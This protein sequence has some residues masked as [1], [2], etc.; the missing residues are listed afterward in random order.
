MAWWTSHKNNE[1]LAK[2]QKEAEQ[3]SLML[4]ALESAQTA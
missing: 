4:R 2:L 1:Q 3:N